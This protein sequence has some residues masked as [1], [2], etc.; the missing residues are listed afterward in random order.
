MGLRRLAV[1]ALLA[2]IA[3]V[4]L[5]GVGVYLLAHGE[6]SA[7]TS[8][9]TI[10][11]QRIAVERAEALEHGA[12]SVISHPREDEQAWTVEIKEEDAAAWIAERLPGWLANRGEKWPAE[13]SRPRVRF[14]D[15]RVFIGVRDSG[16]TIL[17]LSGG[18]VIDAGE[19]RIVQ[20]RGTIGRLA[21]PARGMSGFIGDEVL[22]GLIA[23]ERGINAG[24]LL[25]D[26]RRVDLER[27]E[28]VD[29]RL[30][31]TCRTSRAR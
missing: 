11:D 23:G 26:G 6:P 21:L 3:I 24:T 20:A 8:A 15:G 30:R 19:L 14:A 17:G 22:R 18:P 10:A 31:L 9:A 13:W 2:G 7:Y 12:A 29:G 1:G 5:V 4:S 27:V 25:D 28:S 16:G